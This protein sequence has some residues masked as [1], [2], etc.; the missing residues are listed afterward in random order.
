[1]ATLLEEMMFGNYKS[2]LLRQHTVNQPFLS[3]CAYKIAALV[4][5]FRNYVT[6]VWV[7]GGLP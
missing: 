7:E 2:S 1:M 4:R 6:L 5:V 3:I